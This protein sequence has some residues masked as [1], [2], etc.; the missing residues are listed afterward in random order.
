MNYL[1]AFKS[2]IR[3]V[4]RDRTSSLE[5]Y[6]NARNPQTPF[7]V[8]QLEREYYAKLQRGSMV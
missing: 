8:E 2:F 3:D 6:I 4:L 7:H 1:H 5:E